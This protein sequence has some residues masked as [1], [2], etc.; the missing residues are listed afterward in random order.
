MQNGIARSAEM[1]SKTMRKTARD[2][3]LV[4]A[5]AF[6]LFPLVAMI[7]LGFDALDLG[8]VLVGIMFVFVALFAGR[9]GLA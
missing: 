1:N 3:V 9:T 5:G 6:V 4:I 7:F 8:L 2:A